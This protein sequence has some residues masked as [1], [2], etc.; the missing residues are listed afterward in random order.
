VKIA[1]LGW[2]SLIWKPEA[3]P[4][5]SEWHKDGPAF[6]IELSRVGDGG[7][8]ATAVCVNAPLTRA[9]WAL[10]NADTLHHA[11]AAL[12]EREQIPVSR[13]DGVGVMVFNSTPAGPLADWAAEKKLDAVIWTALPPRIHGL[14]GRIP[15][16]K[17]V[18]DYLRTLEGEKRQHAQDYLSR[19]PAEFETPYRQAIRTHLG[20]DC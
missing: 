11:V 9:F 3:L 20:W 4:L 18:L 16:V 13:S 10:L 5:A 15:C 7:E 17:D 2:G 14:E 8:L 19:V 1:C 12:R 6:P